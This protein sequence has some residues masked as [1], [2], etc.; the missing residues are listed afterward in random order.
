MEQRVTRAALLAFLT[1]FLASPHAARSQQPQA[2]PV[3]VA[4]HGTVTTPEGAP[5]AGASVTLGH[6]EHAIKTTADQLGQFTLEMPHSYLQGSPLTATDGKLLIAEHMLVDDAKEGESPK[7]VDIQLQPARLIEVAIVD[8]QGVPVPDADVTLVGSYRS[9]D[10]ERTDSAGHATFA[11]APTATLD[12]VL[13]AKA[14][15]GVGYQL[16]RHP[17][18]PASDP[19][20]LPQDH[21]Q[22]VTVKLEPSRTVT[23]HVQ[24]QHGQPIAGVDVVPWYIQL[25][26]HGGHANLG[27]LWS[28]KTDEQGDATFPHIPV[29]NE[30]GIVFWTRKEG[31]IA[32]ERT[33]LKAED[34]AERLVATLLPLTPVSGRVV[35]EDGSP[36]AGAQVSAAGSNGNMDGY[37]GGVVA[38]EAGRFTL[39]VN[40]DCYCMFAASDG[41]QASPAVC[42]I[43]RL[44]E[45]IDDL[46]LKL[47]PAS[48]VRGRLTADGKPASKQY[49]SLYRKA[50]PEYYKLPADE[51]LPHQEGRFAVNPL[52]VQSTPTDEEGRYEFFA[53][54]GDYYLIVNN[55]DDPPHFAISDQRE[56]EHELA[57]NLPPEGDLEGRVVLADKPEQG[58]A[59]VVVFSY[60]EEMR[61]R[62]IRAT[63]DGEG[64]FK[65]QLPGAASLLGAFNEDKSLGAMERIA[66]DQKEV[67]LALRPTATATAVVIDEETGQPAIDREVVAYVRIGKENGPFM[68]GFPA[69]GK[70]DAE[71]R[72]TLRG[73]LIGPEYDLNVVTKHDA[74][75]NARGWQSIGKVEPKVAEELA[76]GELR[77]PKPYRPPT[78]DDDIARAYGHKDVEKR[79]E[80]LLND[81]KLAYYHVLVVAADPEGAAGRRYFEICHF[82]SDRPSPERPEKLHE[83]LVLAVDPKTGRELLEARDLPVPQEKDH[84]AFAILTPA[85]AVVAT[86]SSDD[87]S[88]DGKLN[89]K[90]LGEFLANRETP[91]PNARKLLADSLAQAKRDDKRVLVQVGGPGCGWCVVLA[92]YLDEQKSL[93]EKDYLHVKIDSRMPEAE[94]LIGELREKQE[95]G[96]PWMTILDADGKTLITSD[97]EEGNIGYPGEPKSQEHWLKMLTSTKQRLTDDDV[98]ALMKPLSEKK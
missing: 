45:P 28:T 50:T 68:H 69:S 87:L 81:A 48:T 29:K 2:E 96:V 74:D 39:Q 3:K 53:G 85:G 93:V 97:G 22:P 12:Y 52:L 33:N 13:A 55:L 14:G 91:L 43:V 79:L 40:P 71:G 90:L 82:Y 25:A 42:R 73:L 54:P 20:Q 64:R 21:A 10:A 78:V 98:A 5:A 80:Q 38:D 84:A 77:I 94:E 1:V 58:V 56:I 72:V 7:P 16:F 83:F 76:L 65:H 11:A 4:V 24:D 18:Q 92:R 66:G 26:K 47:Q 59:E 51:Q 88:K 44:D 15:D 89:A 27:S 70:T 41:Q 37:R 17:R 49:V 34:D 60:P 23:I 67:T 30:T 62:H 6:G 32:P 86:A 31:L 57:L 19:Y 8:E 36:A 75:G 63:T 46:E 61:A 9:L 95:G 35:R